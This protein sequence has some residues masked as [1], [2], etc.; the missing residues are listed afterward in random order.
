VET[1]RLTGEL[2]LGGGDRTGQSGR[3]QRPGHVPQALSETG[4]SRR[5]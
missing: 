3:A 1:A 2:G 4:P 5:R